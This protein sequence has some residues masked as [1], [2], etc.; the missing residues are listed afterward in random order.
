MATRHEIISI[1]FRANAAKA[2]PAMDSLREAAKGMNVEI[3][4]TKEA[5]WDTPS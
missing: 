1:D 3:E 5:Q 2:N 4:K